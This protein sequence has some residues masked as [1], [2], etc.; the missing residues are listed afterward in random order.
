MIRTEPTHQPK[1]NGIAARAVATLSPGSLTAMVNVTVN[2]L[3]S[4]RS[5]AEIL[6]GLH[7]SS[8]A[9]AEIK[10]IG[11]IE[12]AKG[13][14]DSFLA[15]IHR[16]QA[17]LL[18]AEASAKRRL[19]DEY[20]AA[21]ERGEVAKNGQPSSSMREGLATAA[22]I[23]LTHKDIHEARQFRDAEQADPGIVRRTL[24]AKLAAGEEPTKAAL[25]DA[26]MEAAR[27]GIKGEPAKSNRNPNYVD[28]PAYRMLLQVLGP[29]RALMEKVDANEISVGVILN[30]FLDADH[31]QRAL[32]D[33]HRARD[34]LNTILETANAH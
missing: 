22:D 28:D 5:S 33:I 10:S 8:V 19:A 23:G 6:D 13:A 32:R 15:D 3:T 18:D 7:K 21:Q 1:P 12:K 24:D 25:R 34:F 27:Q 2:H 17:D 30:A 16:A 11:R 14:H 20:D 26:V 9:Y 29:C 31:R 4:A